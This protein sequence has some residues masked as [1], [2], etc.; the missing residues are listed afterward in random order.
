V[1][2]TNGLRGKKL[3]K[4][5]DNFTYNMALLQGQNDLLNKAKQEAHVIIRQVTNDKY[6]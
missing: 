5:V 3:T 4:V 2:E 6:D 1:F